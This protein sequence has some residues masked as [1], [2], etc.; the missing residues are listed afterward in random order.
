MKIRRS[1]LVIAAAVLVH[2]SALAI[3]AQTTQHVVNCAVTHNIVR[4]D[5]LSR[6]ARTYGTKVASLQQING[7]SGSVIYAGQQLCIRLASNPTPT[8]TPV[9]PT[10]TAYVVQRGDTLSRIARRYGV[11]WRV[12][13]QVNSIS[14]PNR[15]Y[16]GQ[17][18]II[19]DVT[20]Q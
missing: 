5:T 16:A 13:A 10:G 12:L 20:I 3:Q 8:P 1:F 6:L 14:N 17:Q 19:P 9:P 11:S 15:I 7:I 18:L 4:G 2:G